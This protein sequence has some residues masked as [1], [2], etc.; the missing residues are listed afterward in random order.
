LAALVKGLEIEDL[1]AMLY[2]KNQITKL[3]VNIKLEKEFN[4]S[5]IRRLSQ[6]L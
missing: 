5:I 1:P 6:M 2:L 3:E 4:P